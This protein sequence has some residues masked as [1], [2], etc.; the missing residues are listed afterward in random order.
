[1]AYQNQNPSANLMGEY[2]RLKA[3][4]GANGQAPQSIYQGVGNLFGNEQAPQSMY[5]G[6]MG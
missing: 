3:L 4:Q 1:M 5:Q 2:Q 6:I